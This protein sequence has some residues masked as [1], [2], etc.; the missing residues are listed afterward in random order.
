MM[1]TSSSLEDE[2]PL[3]A[4]MDDQRLSIDNRTLYQT[5]YPLAASTVVREAGVRYNYHITWF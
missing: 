3:T 4:A 5:P 2:S 1:S